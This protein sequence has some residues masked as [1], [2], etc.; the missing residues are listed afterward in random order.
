MSCGVTGVRQQHGD[1]ICEFFKKNCDTIMMV[2]G[3]ARVEIS[4]FEQIYNTHAKVVLQDMLC[5][6][7]PEA[8]RKDPI[9]QI[10]LSAEAI[11]GS[12]QYVFA[13][14]SAK[15]TVNIVVEWVR[16]LSSLSPPSFAAVG[17]DKGLKLLQ[18]RL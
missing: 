4:F 10:L 2:D 9:S 3:S 16:S 13:A 1:Y 12:P 18:E 7:L 6:W 15:A 8:P 11:K 14:D 5:A 17:D